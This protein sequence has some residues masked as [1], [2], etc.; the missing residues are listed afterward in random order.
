MTLRWWCG[1]VS[2]LVVAEILTGLVRYW[3]VARALEALTGVN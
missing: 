3:V 1:L 2:A